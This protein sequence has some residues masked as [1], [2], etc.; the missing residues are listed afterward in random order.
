MYI[1]SMKV[2]KLHK[3]YNYDIK[4]NKDIT[5]LYGENGS[6]KTT[7]L[8]ML[9]AVLTAN[10]WELFK[11]DFESIILASNERCSI[12]ISK[13]IDKENGLFLNVEFLN[14]D[15]YRQSEKIF[16]NVISSF[17]STKYDSKVSLKDVGLIYPI[18]LEIDRNFNDLYLPISRIPFSFLREDRQYRKNHQKIETDTDNSLEYAIDLITRENRI[19]DIRKNRYNQEFKN[20]IL[21]SSLGIGSENIQDIFKHDEIVDIDKIDNLQIK[22]F[23]MLDSLEI[24]DNH[25]K[26][27]GFLEN[28]KKKL[29]ELLS[30]F[31]DDNNSIQIQRMMTFLFEASEI[32]RMKKIL[33]IAENLE[34]RVSQISARMNLF[35]EIVNSFFE[36]SMEKKEII[37]DNLGKPCFKISGRTEKVGLNYLSSGEKQIIILFANLIF[38]DK[39]SKSKNFRNIFIADEPEISF[40]MLW[41]MK[42]IPNILK[43][44]KKLQ[45]ILA[46]HSP[47][48]VGEF[49]DR[50]FEL[51]KERV[52][53]E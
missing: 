49:E 27:E 8:A 28:Y 53:N 33:P 31:R 47:E 39:Y 17:Q 19:I 1:N 25:A 43:S 12:F 5:I 37:F 51:K 34:K 45:I 2:S 4:F 35:L 38:T 50:M 15:G 44:R 26:I 36:E 32:L 18:V 21:S 13:G 46:T 48:I 52:N 7:I 40:H 11:F 6:G 20:E 9:E 30:V 42:L 29:P 3:V 22:Y 16:Q 23:K 41:Q 10:I 24:S 14:N